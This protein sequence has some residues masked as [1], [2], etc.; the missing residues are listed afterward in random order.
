MHNDKSAL[1]AMSG[2]VDS[3]V[4][5]F[6]MK[7][8]GYNCIGA[9]MKLY[10]DNA[11]TISDEQSCCTTQDIEDAKA[12]AAVLSMPHHLLNFNDNFKEK[13]VDKFVACY[14]CGITPNPCI[15]CNRYLKFEKL[16]ER[17]K[18]LGL[19]YI[20]TGHYAIV[21]YS[22]EL[23]RY[24]LKKSPN[25]AKDQSYVL[26][27]LT[28]EQLAHTIFPLGS[29]TKDEVR[30]IA[31]ANSL[32][33]SRKKDSQ[34]ICFVPD[35]KYADF[36]ENYSGKIYPE[37]NFV[38]TDGNVLG[39]HKGIIR[40]TVGQRK[41]LGLSL[42]APMYV[43]EVNVA[44]NTVILAKDEE[45]YQTTLYADDIN[46]ISIDDIEGKL[47]VY[48]KVRYKHKEAPA[49]IERCTDGRVRVTFDEP[50]RAITKGQAV[51]FYDGDV[52]VGGGTIVE[53]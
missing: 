51:V 3:S 11:S 41:G 48:A 29:M 5:A 52:V 38:D 21:E 13:V 49:T 35:G 31:E 37:G 33:N 25:E 44:D 32:I 17:A 53:V 2:G 14:E 15:D 27:S 4:A 19:D 16:Y 9:T 43:K 28:K 8:K 26:Y 36:I 12:I 7:E 10:S 39:Q 47:R 46:L 1:I 50:Q 22:K 34:D 18:E 23:D 24:L 42:P 20:V 6:L 30:A 40:Y 45:L